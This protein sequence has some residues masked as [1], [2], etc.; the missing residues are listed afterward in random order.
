M[1]YK[2]TCVNCRYATEKEDGEHCGPCVAVEDG[3]G[4]PFGKWEPKS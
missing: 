3:G 1:E 4:E 2:N